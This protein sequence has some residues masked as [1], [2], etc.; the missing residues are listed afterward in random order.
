VRVGPWLGGYI[1]DVIGNYALAFIIANM[2]M[3]ASC[4]FVWLASLI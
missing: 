4:V 1:F 2:T 3:A